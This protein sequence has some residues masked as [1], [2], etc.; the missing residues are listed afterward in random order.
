MENYRNIVPRLEKHLISTQIYSQE[1]T[2]LPQS[3]EVEV[4]AQL[5]VG[6]AYLQQS[7][8]K[9]E[10]V[11]ERYLRNIGTIGVKG[12]L[13]LLQ[14]T[15]AVIGCG[16]LGGL[17]VELLARMGVGTLILVDDDVFEDNNLNRQILCTEADLGKPKVAAAY[18]RILTINPAV[19]IRCYQQRLGPE[20]ARPMLQGAHVVVDALDNLPSRFDLEQ[21]A[22]EL[23]I[24]MVHGAIAGFLG[25]VMTIYPGDP[26]L[27]EI[28]GRPG[29]I[30]R[31]IETETGNLAATPA[32]V[33]SLQAQEVVK[34]LTGVGEPLRG[35][36]F[37]LDTAGGEASVLKLSGTDHKEPA[38]RI[39]TAADTKRPLPVSFAGTSGSGK[40]TLLVELIA[41]LTR[42]Q[43][44]VAAVKH[45]HSLIE[46]D[47]EGKDSWRFR[48]AGAKGAA[49]ISSGQ[50]TVFYQLPSNEAARRIKQWFPDTDIILVEGF[51]G[52]PFPKVLVYR[53]GV[54]E[55]LSPWPKNIIAVAGDVEAARSAG[56][57][58]TLPG[59]GWDDSVAL[60]DF[61]LQKGYIK[62]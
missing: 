36:L 55:K 18:E 56:V 16:G 58:D 32:L 46:L 44:K 1:I 7:A 14:S 43:I 13:S 60:A 15:V 40:T 5:G 29:N 62:D 30:E 53:D 49:F 4:A 51:K 12:Q 21:A 8:L 28:Y 48:L 17:V 6:R 9:S 10:I 23:G 24:P 57:P 20:N 33:A 61:L 54:S 41:E 11:P 52:G 39:S 47:S 27:R 35:R 2:V 3:A 37:Y 38:D 19:D 59:F 45:S 42:R 25:Q 50:A 31:G 34:V 22:Q 26:G